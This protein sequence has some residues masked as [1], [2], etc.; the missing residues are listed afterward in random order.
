MPPQILTGKN[1]LTA[2]QH[3]AAVHRPGSAVQRQPGVHG[4]GQGLHPFRLQIQPGHGAQGQQL[5][6]TAQRDI[7]GAAAGNLLRGGAAGGQ[8]VAQIYLYLCALGADGDLLHLVRRRD[9]SFGEQ[10]PQGQLRQQRRGAYHPEGGLL[11]DING[12]GVL[13]RYGGLGAVRQTQAGK[14]RL[15]AKAVG[16]LQRGCAAFFHKVSLYYKCNAVCQTDSINIPVL[17]QKVKSH[18]A[19]K[20]NAGQ[21]ADCPALR[22]KRQV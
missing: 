8:W 3:K 2:V 19:V 11:V 9:P 17:W 1:D 10:P 4:G 14:G 16:D 21:P 6:R 15:R 13:C 20:R 22:S 7:I 5:H 12:G 18:L